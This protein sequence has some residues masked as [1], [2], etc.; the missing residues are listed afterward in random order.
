MCVYLISWYLE[1]PPVL[2]HQIFFILSSRPPVVTTTSS[3]TSWLR[4]MSTCAARATPS[5]GPASTC[6]PAGTT[7][8]GRCASPWRTASPACWRTSTSRPGETRLT[9]NKHTHFL[10][11]FYICPSPAALPLRT[12]CWMTSGRPE[13]S[14]RERS[15]PRS[16]PESN[17]GST[18]QRSSPRTSS[19]TC[20]FLTET[21]RSP[22]NTQS[23]THTYMHR[24]CIERQEITSLCVTTRT[25]TPWWSWCR[26]WRCCLHAIWQLSPWSSSTTPSPSTGTQQVDSKSGIHSFFVCKKICLR[27]F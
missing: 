11:F 24:I 15:W 3:P 13:R 25:T 16:F 1:A 14:T 19:W 17:F 21:Y 18:T 20:C 7:C 8:W 9:V 5:A 26:L 27:W 10:F 6:S 23:Y 12:P 4:T 2:R 22:T